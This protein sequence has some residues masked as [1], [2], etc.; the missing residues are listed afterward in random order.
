MTITV[1]KTLLRQIKE[2]ISPRF[3]ITGTFEDRLE[4]VVSP[5]LAP[6]TV[7]RIE[8]IKDKEEDQE[9]YQFYF[10]NED[11]AKEFST[12]VSNVN[13]V[14]HPYIDVYLE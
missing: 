7:A 3:N 10:I 4:S 6:S 8:I 1:Y 9:K 12:L 14:Y 11:I 2:V 5:N 13:S